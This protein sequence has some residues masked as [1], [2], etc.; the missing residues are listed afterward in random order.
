[1]DDLL[2]RRC[3]DLMKLASG[4]RSSKND[5]GAVLVHHQKI[6]A[7]AW[8]LPEESWKTDSNPLEKALENHPIPP[9]DTTLF[10]CLKNG[11][12]LEKESGVL[13]FIKKFKIQKLKL[14]SISSKPGVIGLLEKRL[15]GVEV[16]LDHS[17]KSELETSVVFPNIQQIDRPKV[18]LKYAISKDGFIGQSGKMI[19][20]TNH[21]SKRLVHRWRGEIDAIIVGT[22]TVLVDD[23]R[24]NTR[25]GH[26]NSPLRVVLDRSGRLSGNEKVFDGDSP[27][28]IVT[29]SEFLLSK[30]GNI[31]DLECF[32]TPFDSQLLPRLLN[33]LYQ[34]KSCANIMVEGGAALLNSFIKQNLWDEARV[35]RSPVVLHHGIIGP[36]LEERDNTRK[37]SLIDDEL[38]IYKNVMRSIF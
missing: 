37:F 32:V 20:L 18:I 21:Y 36:L 6:I 15:E 8:Q 13:R 16:N 35:F 10:L 1:M 19:W 17:V 28:L 27:T 24:L 9:T 26:G 11:K 2:G 23:P 38:I 4:I 33:Y 7:E 12:G 30:H 31:K 22:N 25:F 14:Y 29:Q 3:F 5:T 34:N